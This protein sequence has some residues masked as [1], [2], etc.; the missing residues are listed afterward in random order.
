MWIQGPRSLSLIPHT[1][2][3]NT[4]TLTLFL[5][6]HGLSDYILQRKAQGSY[7][8]Y[9]NTWTLRLQGGSDQS[10]ILI[11]FL[12]NDTTHLKTIRF[13]WSKNWLAEELTENQFMQWNCRQQRRQHRSGTW[14]SCR[15]S[16]RCSWW[17]T[18]L[19]PWCNGSGLWFFWRI[20]SD[21]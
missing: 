18:P 13:Y 3:C 5:A 6:T 20:C 11:Y 19:P 12:K 15:T 16:P 14:I 9:C 10:G 8:I 4:W 1:I 2:S 21:P 7:I 17:G